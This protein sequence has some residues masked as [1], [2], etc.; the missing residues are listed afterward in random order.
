MANKYLEKIA[1]SKKEMAKA[2][3][4]MVSDKKLVKADRTNSELV[5]RAPK[6]KEVLGPH[7]MP[8]RS[9]LEKV[10]GGRK[11]LEYA[12]RAYGGVPAKTNLKPTAYVSGDRVS[13]LKKMT[14]EGVYPRDKAINKLLNKMSPSEKEVTNRLATLH[15]GDEISAAKRLIGT[16]SKG[17]VSPRWGN[18]GHLS[19]SV[20]IEEGNKLAT[21][22]KGNTKTK[23]LLRKLRNEGGEAK[24]LE[25]AYPGYRFGKTRLN[26]RQKKFLTEKLEKEYIPGSQKEWTQARKELT[27]RVESGKVPKS[28]KE[29]DAEM[30]KSIEKAKAKMKKAK[31]KMKKDEAH[32]IRASQRPGIKEVT[33]KARAQTAMR[34]KIEKGKAKAKAAAGRISSRGKRVVDDNNSLADTIA[35]RAGPKAGT[36]DLGSTIESG[37]KVKKLKAIQERKAPTLSKSDKA[38]IDNMP[39]Q[40]AKYKKDLNEQKRLLATVK[41]KAKTATDTKDPLVKTSEDF[42]GAGVAFDGSPAKGRLA[43]LARK[44]ALEKKS[45]LEKHGV[46]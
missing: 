8:G 29:K 18:T 15:E 11:N 4:A 28:L 5:R 10:Y 31:A 21:L 16:K 40:D 14:E 33:S 3:K 7:A 22:P 36:Q 41:R 34:M 44:K 17:N 30:A 27:A 1:I 19:P 24:A 37:D 42:R 13:D 45:M 39:S 26:R 23:V 12:E 38:Q 46:K 6:G 9:Q 25:A 20:I 43:A 2:I 35:N 32:K